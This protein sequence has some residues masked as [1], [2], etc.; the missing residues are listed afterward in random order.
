MTAPIDLAELERLEREHRL[1]TAS[2][3][4]Y[5]GPTKTGHRASVC[6]GDP[7]GET[8]ESHSC[9]ADI[10]GATE[11]EACA[12]AGA[13]AKLLAAFPSIRDELHRLRKRNERLRESHLIGEPGAFH[14]GICGCE[15]DERGEE[16]HDAD[17]LAA[18]EGAS[19]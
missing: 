2:Y 17:C 4:S 5:E 1:G 15:N 14:C 19:E 11:R 3:V 7:R 16:V 8:E 12:R 10:F 9:L 18:P 6:L 13:V